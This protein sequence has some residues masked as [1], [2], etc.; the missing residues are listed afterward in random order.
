[1]KKV[2][3]IRDSMLHGGWVSCSEQTPENGRVLALFG[4]R[5]EEVCASYVDEGY[6]GG[7]GE[8]YFFDWE[9]GPRIDDCDPHDKA[10]VTHWMYWELPAA[11]QKQEVK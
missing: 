6:I 11:P 5:I 4:K 9:S 2:N 7:D 3:G 10:I 1:M 8:F